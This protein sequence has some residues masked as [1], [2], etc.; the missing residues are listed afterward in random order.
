MFRRFESVS[1][2]HRH[3]Q[4]THHPRH[5]ARDALLARERFSDNVV[6]CAQILSTLIIG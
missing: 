4:L 3:L 2:C 6:G 5:K 1:E